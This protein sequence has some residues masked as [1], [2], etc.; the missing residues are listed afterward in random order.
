MDDE[1]MWSAVM[2]RD[3]D[4]DG[5]FVYAVRSTGVY[6]RP[7]CP[8]RPAKREN[9]SF[10]PDAGAAEA[11]GFRPCKRCRPAAPPSTLT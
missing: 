7:S 10:H 2:R 1:A 6:C 11:A 5:R 4:G 3:R 8:S 9:V